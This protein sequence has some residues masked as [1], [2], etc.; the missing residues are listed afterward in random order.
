MHH[1]RRRPKRQ[2]SG[3]L[4]CKPYK[5]NHSKLD[6]RDPPRERRK[7]QEEGAEEA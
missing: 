2:R 5:G 6:D 4:M 7:L 3:C 1:K